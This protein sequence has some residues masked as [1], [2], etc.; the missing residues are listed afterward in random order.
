MTTLLAVEERRFEISSDRKVA[1]YQ[2]RKGQSRTG[3]TPLKNSFGLPAGPNKSCIGATEWCWDSDNPLCYAESISRLFTNVGL[4]LERNWET[5]QALKRSVPAL[6]SALRPMLDS[7]VTECERRDVDPVFRWFWDGDIPSANFARAISD[8]CKE[9]TQVRFWL[10]TRH[11]E[12]VDRLS[13]NDNLTVY[14]SVDPANIVAAQKCKAANTWV[15]L[16]F[17]ADTWEETEKLASRFPGERK[18]PRCPELTKKIPL[19]VCNSEESVSGVGACVEGNMCIDGVNNVRF[20][21]A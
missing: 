14:L 16:A 10:Y 15:K 5:F 19:V 11:F 2:R 8:L 13:C 7:F 6:K 17:C 4:L 18:G 9:Y 12:I 20:A 1:P 21:A 3:A